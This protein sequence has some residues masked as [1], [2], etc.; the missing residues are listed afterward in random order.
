MNGIFYVKVKLPNGKTIKHQ[1]YDDEI[2]TDCGGCGKEM[3]VDIV[4]LA[5]S[6]LNHG[7]DLIGTIWYC[8]KECL[9]RTSGHLQVIA[10]A[11]PSD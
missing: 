3:R 2:Y 7:T 6:I 5:D 10:G 8:S 1:L 9:H 4:E 11:K